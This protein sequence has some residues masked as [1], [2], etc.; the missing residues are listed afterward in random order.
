MWRTCEDVL[1]SPQESDSYSFISK[2]AIISRKFAGTVSA[3]V[4][5]HF[6][7][8]IYRC[9]DACFLEENCISCP[10][11]WFTTRFFLNDSFRWVGQANR[12]AS[13]K[14]FFVTLTQ[15]QT[16]SW[17]SKCVRH[18]GLAMWILIL[19]LDLQHLA[20]FSYMMPRPTWVYSVQ[21]A[22]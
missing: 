5:L 14:A 9:S 11:G 3:Q 17:S 22:S 7:V 20:C 13:T 19:D 6:I 8:S 4:C 10:D 12:F 16:W 1:A 2:S 15:K 21:T 18:V